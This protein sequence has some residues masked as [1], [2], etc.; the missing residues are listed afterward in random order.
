[1]TDE[2][3]S[4]MIALFEI[5]DKEATENKMAVYWSMLK[6]YPILN[7]RQ[8]AHAW[9]K[10]SQFMPKP[11]DLLKMLGGVGYFSADE[12]WAI[13]VM[14][15]DEMNT[16]VWTQ[17]I[18]NAWSLAE[19]IYKKGDRVGARKTFIEAYERNINNAMINNTQI[20]VT[21]SLGTDRDLR[22]S[23]IS[24]AVN[25][26][27]LS[28]QKAESYL[29]QQQNTFAMLENKKNQ[30]S[31]SEHIEKLRSMISGYKVTSKH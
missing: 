1:M 28:K 19:I 2:F 24:K 11:A 18:A 25:V 15:S 31:Q 4:V 21:V 17:E 16:V 6:H 3:R 26:G 20:E 14:A 30:E 13:A 8:V 29:P 7:V 23:A 12:A 22:L 5:Y 9:M 27:L 10:K